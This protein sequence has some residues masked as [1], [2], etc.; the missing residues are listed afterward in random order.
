MFNSPNKTANEG[1]DEDDLSDL[2]MDKKSSNK[3]QLVKILSYIDIQES[4]SFDRSRR[5]RMRQQLPKFKEHIIT[6]DTKW[7]I[8][9]SDYSCMM[10]EFKKLDEYKI[11]GKKIDSDEEPNDDEY[12]GPKI[13]KYDFV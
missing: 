13:N 9:N 1:D 5:R 3:D 11:K 2:K 8:E 7:R 6:L 10:N 4:M 12:F